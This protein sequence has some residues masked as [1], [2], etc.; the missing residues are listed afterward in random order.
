MIPR[1]LLVLGLFYFQVCSGQVND[2]TRVPGASGADIVEAV[3]SL[4]HESCIFPND[5]LYL[6]RLAYVE[7]NDGTDTST[8][9]PGYD[10]GIWQASL[11]V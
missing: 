11:I 4:I 3:I 6:R 5:R 10:G 2:Q 1:I 8:Y 7:S 9:R